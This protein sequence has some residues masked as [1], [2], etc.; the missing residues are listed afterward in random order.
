MQRIAKGFMV[1]FLVAST[2]FVCAAESHDK[3]L[4][5]RWDKAEIILLGKTKIVIPIFTGMAPDSR[6]K[7]PRAIPPE[8]VGMGNGVMHFQYAQ[9]IGDGD[10]AVYLFAN[11]VSVSF[12][13]QASITEV[14]FKDFMDASIGGMTAPLG[15]NEAM[16]SGIQLEERPYVYS[17]SDRHFSLFMLTRINSNLSQYQSNTT[18]L[19]K[20]K[21]FSVNFNVLGKSLSDKDRGCVISQATGWRDAILAT[22]KE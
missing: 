9:K 5:S 6:T 12:F 14:G 17:K 15:E 18:M 13:E 10:T 20:G 11:A 19:V 1:L 3:D 4:P 22:N 16:L 7:F 21:V 8:I 2:A